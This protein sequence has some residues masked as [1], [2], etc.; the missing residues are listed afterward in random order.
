MLEE[1]QQR[2]PVVN[3][4]MTILYA[5]IQFAE[6]EVAAYSLRNPLSVDFGDGKDLISG[7]DQEM[8]IQEADIISRTI[9]FLDQSFSKGGFVLSL[10]SPASQTFSPRTRV[11]QETSSRSLVLGCN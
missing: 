4:M 3:D 5:T 9:Y 2:F 11:I 7:F 6:Q 10:S 8:I 1:L